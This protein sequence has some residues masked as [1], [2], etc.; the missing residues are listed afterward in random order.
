[1]AFVKNVKI[2]IAKLISIK[3]EMSFLMKLCL[4]PSRVG[5]P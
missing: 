4:K 1:M 5:C 3:F 2:I